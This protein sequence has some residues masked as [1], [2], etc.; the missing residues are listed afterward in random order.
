MVVSAYHW[1]A[2]HLQWRHVQTHELGQIQ[3]DGCDHG[4]ASKRKTAR[5]IIL[6]FDVE[7][8]TETKYTVKNL[9][10]S[11]SFLMQRMTI[12]MQRSTLARLMCCVRGCSAMSSRTI[13]KI[14]LDSVRTRPR[15]ATRFHRICP[16]GRDSSQPALLVIPTLFRMER[17]N[18]HAER[19]HRKTYTLST[20]KK[21]PGK[22]R[23]KRC[24][25]CCI[26]DPEEGR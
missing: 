16:S 24:H 2:V 8:R 12:H 14:K 4:N 7:S 26:V 6:R 25:C 20:V 10:V 5:R 21:K 1:L 23:L 11:Q 18:Q 15:T 17:V 9:S 13:A 22:K 3:S 19:T